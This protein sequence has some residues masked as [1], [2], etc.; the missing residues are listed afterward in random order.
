MADQSDGAVPVTFPNGRTALV[1]QVAASSRHRDL[2]ER[3]ALPAAGAVIVVVGAADSLP[4][5]LVPHLSVLF[6]RAL[7]TAAEHAG[8][9]V[10]D[11]GT[12]A[13]VMAVTGEAV[14]EGEGIVLVGVAP[15]AKVSYPGQPGDAEAAAL[16]PNHSHFLLVDGAD[17]GGETKTMFALADGLVARSA[18]AVGLV[19]GGGQ[20]ARNEV[21][22][23]VRRGWP[24]VVIAGTGGLADGI[25]AGLGRRSRLTTDQ[26]DPVLGEIIRYGTFDVVALK[27]EPAVLAGV[28]RRRL[29]PDHSL[30]SAWALH[31]ELDE[32]AKRRQREF[33]SL[34]STILWLAVLATLLAVTAGTLDTH[35]VLEDHWVRDRLLRY[36]LILIPIAMTAA[37]G[38]SARFRAGTKWVV[39]RGAAEAVKREI[40]RYRARCGPYGP[41]AQSARE[42][43]LAERVG[44]ISGSVMKTD[45][46]LGA[47]EPYKGPIPPPDSVAGGDD[48]LSVLSAEQYVR[49]RLR[50]QATWYRAKTVTLERTLRRLRWAGIAFGGLGTFLAAVGLELWIAVTTAVVGAITTYFEYMQIEST[51]LHYN[52]A[53]TDLETIQRWWISL[54]EDERV[55]SVT[56]NRLVEQSERV[57]HSESAGWVQDMH[58]AMTELRLQQER[59][60][61]EAASSPGGAARAGAAHAP[62]PLPTPPTPRG[63]DDLATKQA[64]ATRTARAKPRRPPS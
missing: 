1:A 11:G 17:W 43:R 59:A 8:A 15:S 31:A 60:E 54:P 53:S 42:V 58:D 36:A 30:E 35:R 62:V 32:A 50:D 64:T 2:V 61:D 10:V 34:Q 19:V 16:E 25:A 5:E 24:V 14:A 39:L 9:V 3:L 46:N 7:V 63:P 52:Q 27:S 18:K 51:L 37:V 57:M 49:W 20:V 4:P 44:M 47:V 56:V 33:R 26:L 29:G 28:L 40:Y 55:Q 13:G 22:E 23:M 21:L 6:F 48:G 38:A 12:D 45:V 41:G